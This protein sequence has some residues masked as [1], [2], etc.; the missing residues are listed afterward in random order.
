MAKQKLSSHVR[1]GENDLLTLLGNIQFGIIC[2]YSLLQ[3]EQHM[4]K[5][6]LLR[7][8]TCKSG[9]IRAPPIHGYSLPSVCKKV[10]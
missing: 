7:D 6:T 1:N 5:D 10:I 9:G 3:L 8:A 4:A 2:K